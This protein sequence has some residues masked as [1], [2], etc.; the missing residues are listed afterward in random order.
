MPIVRFTISETHKF[1]VSSMTDAEQARATAAFL[2]ATDSKEG[3][4]KS[5]ADNYFEL[6]DEAFPA[7]IGYRC[8]ASAPVLNE[9]SVYVDSYGGNNRTFVHYE[10]EQECLYF[11]PKGIPFNVAVTMASIAA[12]RGEIEQSVVITRPSAQRWDISAPEGI[13]ASVLSDVYGKQIKAY[14]VVRK[15]AAV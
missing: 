7:D 15:E 9:R 4:V 1:P 8:C 5:D 11:A 14:P 12:A 3:L 6:R 2:V 10:T 13:P